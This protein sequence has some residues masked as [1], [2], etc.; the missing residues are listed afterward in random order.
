MQGSES[1]PQGLSSTSVSMPL[2]QPQFIQHSSIAALAVTQ[3]SEVLLSAF[4]HPFQ[5]FAH[6]WSQPS[7]ASMLPPISHHLPALQQIPVDALS[8]GSLPLVQ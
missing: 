8:S 6:G 4:S 1:G 3:F 7:S 2:A 5:N